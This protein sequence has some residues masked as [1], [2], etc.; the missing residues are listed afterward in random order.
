MSRALGFYLNDAGHTVVPANLG[1]LSTI[2]DHPQ[3]YTLSWEK[4][5]I[6]Q[7]FQVVYISRGKGVFQSKQGRLTPINAGDALLL[8]PGEWHRYQ[9][10]PEVGWTQFWIHFGGDYAN[11]LMS[12]EPL[13]SLKPVIQIGHNKALFQLFSNLAETMYSKPSFNPWVTTAQG[14]QIL[15]HLAIADQRHT[16]KYSDQVE[17]ARCHIYEHVGQTIDYRGLAQ[18]LGFSS[19]SVF[20]QEFDKV[21]GLPHT[22][23]QLEIRLDKA[24]ELLCG[25]T[26]SIGEIADQ[27]GFRDQYYFARFFKAKTGITASE[28]RQTFSG[29]SSGLYLRGQRNFSIHTGWVNSHQCRRRFSFISWKMVSLSA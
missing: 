1:S 16:T 24:K 29:V 19:Y 7:E 8:Y 15:A 11:K 3:E 18:D 20:R 17:A 25:T 22:Q 10:D 12:S 23:Y 5:R 2:G 28:Y 13:S 9:P 4:G 14:I 27:L 21:T 6:L 26:L